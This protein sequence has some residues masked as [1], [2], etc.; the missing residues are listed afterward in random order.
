M[1][2]KVDEVIENIPALKIK[3]GEVVNFSDKCIDPLAT[4]IITESLNYALETSV[5]RLESVAKINPHIR[6]AVT[7]D[8]LPAVKTLR[9]LIE[10]APQCKTNVLGEAPIL[11]PPA[12]P[13]V[14]KRETAKATKPKKPKKETEEKVVPAE[15]EEPPLAQQEKEILAGLGTAQRKSLEALKE[16]SQEMY[17]SA[18]ATLAGR[19][20]VKIIKPP[21]AIAVGK[22]FTLK[23]NGEQTK[24]LIVP[25]AIVKID[26]QVPEEKGVDKLGETSK[27]AKALMG[28]K[29]GDKLE[30][31]I[32]GE[33]KQAEILDVKEGRM[34]VKED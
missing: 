27:L 2:S 5:R 12:K 22:Q 15:G 3:L 7:H 4:Q 30:I 24:K 20:P 16:Q 8:V 33:T 14:A 28:K 1:T 31:D 11:A 6:E 10:D 9:D 23:Y 34:T 19:E 25:P 18:L 13:K 26:K 21:Q 32:G 17:E 29:A